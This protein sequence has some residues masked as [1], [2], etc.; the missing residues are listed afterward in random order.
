MPESFGQRQSSNRSFDFEQCLHRFFAVLTEC[1]SRWIC[2]SPAFAAGLRRDRRPL[3][4]PHHPA[5]ES[6]VSRLRMLRRAVRSK[7]AGQEAR[8]SLRQ[9][10]GERGGHLLPSSR[11][12]PA[13]VGMQ[14]PDFVMDEAMVNRGEFRQTDG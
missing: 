9:F 4:P 2:G 7:N 1:N 3:R 10:C 11:H 12:G 8:R 5:P 13:I 6:E 14:A